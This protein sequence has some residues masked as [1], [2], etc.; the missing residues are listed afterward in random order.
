M[1]SS[2]ITTDLQTAVKIT[3]DSHNFDV[4][5]SVVDPQDQPVIQRIQKDNYMNGNDVDYHTSYFYDFDDLDDMTNDGGARQEDVQKIINY[6][7]EI[8]EDDIEHNI[9]I[10]CYAGASRSPSVAFLAW[11]LSGLDK[12]NALDKV[13]EK[14]AWAVPNTRILFLADK[15]LKT[16][17]LY[18]GMYEFMKEFKSNVTSNN[19]SWV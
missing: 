10:H 12:E 13:R 18:F 16:R 14:A 15:F 3:E 8:I 11:V 1:I 4:W 17:G 19:D 2:I 6:L 7:E 9:L 5:I